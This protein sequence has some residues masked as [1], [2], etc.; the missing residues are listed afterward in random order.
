MKK[1]YLAVVN[2]LPAVRVGRFFCEFVDRLKSC[3]INT[4]IFSVCWRYKPDFQFFFSL[5]LH[6]IEMSVNS[7][8]RSF[9]LSLTRIYSPRSKK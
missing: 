7:I 8:D 1:T 9:K 5:Q 4:K 2:P 6:R 3:G